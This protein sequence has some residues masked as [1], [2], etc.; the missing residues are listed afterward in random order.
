MKFIS[1]LFLAALPVSAATISQW[2]FNSTTDDLTPGTGSSAPSTGTGTAATLSS[3]TPSFSS[4]GANGGSSDPNTTD[5]SGWGITSFPAATS[6]DLTAGVQFL[7]DTTGYDS[8]TVGYDIRH[9]NSASRYEAVQYTLNGSTWTTASFFAGAAGDTWFNNRSI[10]LSAISGA[11]NN[12]NFGFRIVSAFE[13][14]ATGS[15]AAS[16]IASNTGSAYATTGTW[17]F[18]MVTVSGTVIPEPASALLGSLGVLAL[19]RRRR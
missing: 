9:S 13:S 2:N 1:V 17:R 18:D 6:S 7:I 15:G 12:P 3:T 11:S 4:G 8:I 16:Y 5:D 19:L 10:D 14:T